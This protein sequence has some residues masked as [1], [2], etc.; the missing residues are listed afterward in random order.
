MDSK[1]S[2]MNQRVGSTVLTPQTRR[3][4]FLLSAVSMMMVV[5]IS[6][7]II[8][9]SFA[10]NQFHPTTVISSGG[11][12]QLM[13]TTAAASAAA[14]GGSRNPTLVSMTARRRRSYDDEDEDEKEGLSPR[15]TVIPRL[16][17]MSY[18]RA[19]GSST[20]EEEG[21]SAQSSSSSSVAVPSSSTTSGPAFVSPKFELQY[22][23]NK[24]ETRNRV[25]V[26]RQAY[27]EGMVIAICNG[28]KAKHMIADNLHKSTGYHI[29]DDDHLD[30]LRV[31]TD[32]FDLEKV[33]DLPTGRI[34]DENGNTVLE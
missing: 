26:S 28:C 30:L 1:Q 8:P 24:C 2:K 22:T 21:T 9:S 5:S 15:P 4:S 20:N 27:R 14:S 7:S 31:S 32:V 16:P 10:F 6:M 23:C 25:L 18:W 34:R 13:K 3:R 12:Q 17:P 11:R 29:E 33:L 19:T